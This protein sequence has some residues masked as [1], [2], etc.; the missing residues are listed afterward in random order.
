MDVT[1]LVVFVFYFLAVLLIGLYSGRK[2]NDTAEDYF[3]AGRKLPWYAVGLSMIGSNIST[4]HFIGMVGAAYL[5]GIS[6]ANWDLTA[7]I[8]MA[9]L[10]FFF[11]PYY[12]RAK[13]FTIPQYLE[14]RYNKYTRTIFAGLTILHLTIVLL[15]GALY[16]GG[17]IFQEI[18][19]ADE[20]VFT[21]HGEISFSLVLGILIIAIT[22]GIYSVYGG[23]NSVVWT[24]VFQVVLLII[25]GVVVI[26]YASH[27]AGGLARVWETN[28][29]FDANR[30]H[31]IQP[32]T[33]TFAPWTGIATIWFTL[34]IW[35]NCTNQFYIQRCFG[36]KDEWNARMGVLLAAF[37]KFFMP[38]LIVLPGVIALTIYGEGIRED[39]IFMNLAQDFLPPILVSLVLTGMAAAIMSTVSSVL[40]SSS[41]IFTI[42]IYQR[43]IN[44]DAPQKKIVRMGRWATV[45]ILV[46][47]IIWAPFI[48]LFGEG[49]F[50]YLQEMAGFFAPPIAILFI[51]AALWKKANSLA[52]NITLVAG[53][54]FGI[55][56]KVI[57]S[58]GFGNSDHF[59]V[60]FL[61]R[62]LLNFVFCL[63]LFFAIAM[64]VSV[65]KKPMADII[66]KPS[67][68]KL[69]LAER[70]KYTGIRSFMGWFVAVLALRILAYV[71]F[72]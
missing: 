37:M 49:L 25:A 32:S 62:A 14:R 45:V 35:Y 50:V 68:A 53:F 63:L 23:L 40:N 2:K 12:F 55:S 33:D 31:L 7:F 36:A 30:L 26:V 59:I 16:A 3:L 4:E 1:T 43:F 48:L 24:D 70:K 47:G 34:G 51:M 9:I 15:A 10:I 41:T 38:L 54:I 66:W 13:L 8:P 28:G 22:T 27:E 5:Y 44:A 42:D 67:Y 56:L 60:P 58:V 57:V 20:V 29:N 71:F 19:Y 69:P 39:R 64:S 6:P 52:A 21:G 11:L 17:L 65:K 46:I 18:F 61:N 72:W